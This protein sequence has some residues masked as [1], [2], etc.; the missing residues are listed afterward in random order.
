MIQAARLRALRHEHDAAPDLQRE[1]RRPLQLAFFISANLY[2]GINRVYG[3]LAKEL[4]NR[5]HQVTVIIPLVPHWAY[6]QLT[7]RRRLGIVRWSVFALAHSIKAVVWEALRWRFR[8]VGGAQSKA[9]VRRCFLRASVRQAGDADAYVLCNN[10]YQVEELEGLE[11]VGERVVQFIQHYDDYEDPLLQ[12]QVRSAYRRPFRRVTSCQATAQALRSK[13]VSIDRVVFLGI[14]PEWFHPATVARERGS[15]LMYWGLE[16][17]K[18][19]Q[20]GLEAME[21]LRRRFPDVTIR[22]LCP[23]DRHP[24]PR[25]YERAVALDDRSLGELLRAHAIFVFPSLME[26]FG[27]PPLEAMACGCAVVATTVGAV[28]EFA[29]HGRS[30]YLVKPGDTETIVEGVARLLEDDALRQRIARG[31]ELAA[32]VHTWAKSAQAFEEFLYASRQAVSS[33]PLHP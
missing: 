28:E 27:L 5:G 15:V 20:I 31:G 4:A 14:N 12:E 9:R 26:G 18:G 30:A 10:W 19:A 13:D 6:H 29:T 22:L 25:G 17:R 8:W 2:G 21:R 11:A 32:S 3:E 7:T 23:S 33:A 1:R 16:A 24:L